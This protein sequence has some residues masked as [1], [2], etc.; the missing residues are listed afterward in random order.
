MS[1]ATAPQTPAKTDKPAAAPAAAAPTPQKAPEKEQKAASPSASEAPPPV[2][3]V[4]K[5]KKK[6]KKP[7]LFEK[8]QVKIGE[9][10]QVCVQLYQMLKSKDHPSRK[11]AALFFVFLVLAL[12]FGGMGLMELVSRIKP[13][14]TLETAKTPENA[15]TSEHDE[16]TKPR[17]GKQ[18]FTVELGKFII[19]LLPP[20]EDPNGLART[21]KMA[22]L[23]LVAQCDTPGTCH[24]LE[25]T[26][27]AVRDRVTSIF[28][29][30]RGDYLTSPEGKK[31]LKKQIIR[32]INGSL[33][34]GEVLEIF[35]VRMV[36]A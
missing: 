6:S 16:K 22:E 26:L 10:F 32:K 8:A 23:E 7:S 36:I 21:L 18:F 2:R 29:P 5:K 13:P 27:D 14:Q 11:G 1:A 25:K 34:K 12:V 35:I 9:G 4:R 33:P 30:M 28:S 3:K 17:D 20:P 19:E 24:F 15:E 31:E